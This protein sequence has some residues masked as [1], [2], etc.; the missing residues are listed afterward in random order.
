[1]SVCVVSFCVCWGVCVCACM[2]VCVNTITTN[3]ELINLKLYHKT[4]YENSSDEL[5][6]YKV[7]NNVNVTCPALFLFLD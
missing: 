4:V 6:K 3:N 2:C 7:G 1:M 5:N